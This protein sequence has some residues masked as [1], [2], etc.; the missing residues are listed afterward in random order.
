M[1]PPA[2][3][4]AKGKGPPKGHCRAPE[5]EQD[6][7]SS[8]PQESGGPRQPSGQHGLHPVVTYCPSSIRSG[9]G[10]GTRSWG[11][12]P[13]ARR[14]GRGSAGGVCTGPH[15]GRLTCCPDKQPGPCVTTSLLDTGQRPPR[16]PQSPWSPGHQ[17]SSGGWRW[18]SSGHLARVSQLTQSVPI[19]K[20]FPASSPH[21][22]EGGC[23]QLPASRV[24]LG[25][26]G[27]SSARLPGL[28]ETAVSPSRP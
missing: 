20:V 26:R 22:V 25:K 17:G 27:G 3:H 18:H 12:A 11:T 13:G 9:A 24:C 4:K 16:L 6:P 28:R 23:H 21:Q 14:G 19:H 10:R 1:G 8:S 15:Q 7:P 2:G 5:R